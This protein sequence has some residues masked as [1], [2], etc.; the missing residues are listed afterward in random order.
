[1]HRLFASA[2]HFSDLQDV[3]DVSE[4]RVSSQ[5]G[6]QAACCPVDFQRAA[7]KHDRKAQLSVHRLQIPTMHCLWQENAGWHAEPF[8]KERQV[9]MDVR[10]LSDIGREQES[11]RQVCYVDGKQASFI[12][13]MREMLPSLTV[14]ES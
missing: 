10:R 3:S 12:Q 6:M 14:A 7:T 13:G 9:R 4:R 1:M 2:M 8:C 11:I 5:E